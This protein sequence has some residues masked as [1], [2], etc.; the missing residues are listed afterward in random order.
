MIDSKFTYVAL[1]VVLVIGM[2]LG[3]AG[4]AVADVD[5]LNVLGDV[6]ESALKTAKIE[7]VSVKSQSIAVRVSDGVAAVGVGKRGETGGIS[8][9]NR[10]KV[11]VGGSVALL[12][13]NWSTH[14][15]GINCGYVVDGPTTVYAVNEFGKI[16][17]TITVNVT[18]QTS[19]CEWA[20]F[21]GI[22]VVVG[23]PN[24]SSTETDQATRLKWL[25]VVD[26]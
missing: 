16:T 20:S 3:F 15:W 25:E 19:V 24:S 4:A 8:I 12:P 11:P 26:G 7:N 18:E 13:L 6:D 23:V 2:S 5:D 22:D 10:E 1:V 9:Y 21:E 17:D 14:G